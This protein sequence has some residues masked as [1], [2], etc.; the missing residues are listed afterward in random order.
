MLVDGIMNLKSHLLYTSD[1]EW[2]AD[3]NLKLVLLGC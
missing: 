1:G 2:L 3:G